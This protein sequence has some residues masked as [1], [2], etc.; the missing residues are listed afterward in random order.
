V[1][2]NKK[3]GDTELNNGT[4]IHFWEVF[5]CE[6]TLRIFKSQIEYAV[7]LYPFEHRV[8][9]FLLLLENLL[10]WIFHRTHFGT[11]SIRIYNW[12]YWGWT[13]L[14][15][16]VIDFVHRKPRCQVLP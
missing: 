14:K 9:F 10:G 7:C 12:R 3:V 1:G 15:H 2:E 8:L 13:G 6:E 4:Q 16:T 11:E 5:I